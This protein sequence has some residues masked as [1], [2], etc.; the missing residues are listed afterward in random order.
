MVK[1]SANYIV[2][3]ADA[4]AVEPHFQ[5]IL[6]VFLVERELEAGSRVLK[7]LVGV[8]PRRDHREGAEACIIFD[9]CIGDVDEDECPDLLPNVILEPDN[10]NERNSLAL[11]L[12]SDEKVYFFYFF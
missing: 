1:V 6:F 4:F 11:D 10:D 3:N 5:A 9:F 7:F 2:K 12:H 8:A